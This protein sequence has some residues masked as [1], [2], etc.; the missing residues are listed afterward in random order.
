MDM[1]SYEYRKKLM[2]KIIVVVLSLMDML[3]YRC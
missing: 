3:S 2:Q 1:L